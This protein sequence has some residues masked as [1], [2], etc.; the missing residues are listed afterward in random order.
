VRVQ[1]D[2][3]T[4]DDA[5]VDFD[6]KLTVL[7]E[8]LDDPA[9][10]APLDVRLEGVMR[11]IGPCYRIDGRISAGGTL[12]CSRCLEPVSWQVDDS[13]AVEYRRAHP[14]DEE[15]ELTDDE[16]DVAF[17]DGDVLDLGE[18]AAEQLLLA[19][20]MR[21]VCDEQCAGLCPRCGANRNRDGACVCEPEA[22]PRWDALREIKGRESTN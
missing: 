15:V 1:I 22:D 3:S 18:V 19:L 13:F 10:S 7:P 8:R 11:P 17:L 4:I 9:V 12:A 14:D 21:I 20:P 5:P 6:E 2:L 16:L